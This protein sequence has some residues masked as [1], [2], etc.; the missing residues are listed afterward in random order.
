MYRTFIHYTN[1]REYILDV[2]LCI[3]YIIYN[4]YIN[5]V[6]DV[7]FCLHYMTPK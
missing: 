6:D 7:D 5:I 1:I 2:I 4:K 3:Y